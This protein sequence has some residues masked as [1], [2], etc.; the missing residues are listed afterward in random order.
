[1]LCIAFRAHTDYIKDEE[2]TRSNI[3]PLIIQIELSQPNKPLVIFF[4]DVFPPISQV[5]QY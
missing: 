5:E 3:C 1:M 2:L 4:C